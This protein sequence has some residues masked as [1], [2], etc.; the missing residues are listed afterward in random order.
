MPCGGNVR[1]NQTQSTIVKGAVVS[2]Y[3]CQATAAAAAVLAVPGF[4]RRV[5]LVLAGTLPPGDKGRVAWEHVELVFFILCW[6]P[7][8]CEFRP[9]FT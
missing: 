6:V 7:L 1:G 9:P 3:L 5:P 8:L 2:F 4:N